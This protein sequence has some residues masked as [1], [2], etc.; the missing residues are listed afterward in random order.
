MEGLFE[1]SVDACK[2]YLHVSGNR[3]DLIRGNERLWNPVSSVHTR[4]RG[5]I[6]AK[7][8][9]LGLLCKLCFRGGSLRGWNN[10]SLGKSLTTIRGSIEILFLD[11]LL[12]WNVRK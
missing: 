9:S 8:R 1:T 2:E 4:N 7:V 10:S 11:R 5:T 3:R 12:D 6:I